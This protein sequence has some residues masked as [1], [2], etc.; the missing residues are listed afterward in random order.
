MRIL[1]YAPF[2]MLSFEW[3]APPAFPAVREQK[4]WVVVLMKPVG[5]AA[6]TVSLTH[7]G[8]GRGEEWDQVYAYFTRA[9]DIV[10]GR[11]RYRFDVGPVDWEDP[12]RPP[13]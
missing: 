12:Y 10:L 8:W 4:T 11:L 5:E 6:T 7:L 1:S 9:W 13:T 3:N 2:E